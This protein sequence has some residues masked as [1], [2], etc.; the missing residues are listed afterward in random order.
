[1][2]CRTPRSTPTHTLFPYTTRFLSPD[3]KQQADNQGQTGNR[4]QARHLSSS[5]AN[6][7]R[8]T[9]PTRGTLCAGR[10]GVYAAVALTLVTYVTILPPAINN[11][12]GGKIV[13]SIRKIGSA[14]CRERVCK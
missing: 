11:F 2:L 13:A 8:Q 1:M 12:A 14:T 4:Y 10:G 6:I 9:T 5:H 3:P 7:R